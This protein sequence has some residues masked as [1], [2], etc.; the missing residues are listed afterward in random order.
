MALFSRIREGSAKRGPDEI[1]W[2]VDAMADAGVY[3]SEPV[4]LAV[5]SGLL[6]CE[7]LG[8]DEAR[9]EVGGDLSDG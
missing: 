4:L 3:P 6:N 2:D 7:S 9:C 5:G 8:A 1:P